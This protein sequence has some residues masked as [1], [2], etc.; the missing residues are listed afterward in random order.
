MMKITK[1]QYQLFIDKVHVFIEAFGL[2]SW[3]ITFKFGGTD[4]GDMSD[5]VFHLGSRICTFSLSTTSRT[6]LSD[7]R[8]SK[9]AFH[10]VCELF[11]A[12]FRIHMNQSAE[13]VDQV[14]HEKIRVLEN[15]LYG[16]MVEEDE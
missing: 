14:I 1:K 15:I 2:K 6:K 5:V 11:L 8:I 7:K 9:L 16:S 13:I 3:D 4:P 12:D 10:E